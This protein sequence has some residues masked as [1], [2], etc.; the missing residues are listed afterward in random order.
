MG[1]QCCLPVVILL[2]ASRLYA[3]S[4]ILQTTRYFDL[5][6]TMWLGCNEQ[7]IISLQFLKLNSWTSCWMVSVASPG[8]VTRRG[9]AGN[10][11]IVHLRRTSGPGAAAAR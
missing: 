8:F 11:V 3:L 1:M 2:D 9:K 7:V 5:Y 6:L 4:H 10:L